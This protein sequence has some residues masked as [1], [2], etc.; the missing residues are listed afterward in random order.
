MLANASI[1]AGGGMR[2]GFIVTCLAVLVLGAAWWTAPGV[3]AQDFFTPN[4]PEVHA[5]GT[6]TFRLKAPDA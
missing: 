5:D 2:A 6:V 4:S 1:I 3:R